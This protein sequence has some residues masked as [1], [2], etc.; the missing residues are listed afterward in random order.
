RAR[1]RDEPYAHLYERWNAA[2]A[3]GSRACGARVA[4]DGNGGDQLFQNSDVFLADLFRSGHWLTLAR[5][6]KA[7]PRGGFRSFFGTVVQ[8]N[9]TPGLHSVAT[10]MRRGRRLRNYLERPVAPWIDAGFAARHELENRDRAFTGR[11]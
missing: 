8:P 4:L 5:E 10:A 9:M 3:D 7:R 6:W 1:S 11:S 2:L